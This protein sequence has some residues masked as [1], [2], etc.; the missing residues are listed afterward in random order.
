MAI[1]GIISQEDI[2]TLVAS[3]LANNYKTIELMQSRKSQY[4]TAKADWESIR[5]ASSQLKASL[6]MLATENSFYSRTASSS[7]A[8]I[9]SATA[10]SDA[11][12]GTYSLTDI[13]LAQAAQK[14]SASTLGL[15]GAGQAYYESTNSTGNVESFNWSEDGADISDWTRF[16]VDGTNVAETFDGQTVMRQSV[17]VPGYGK[18]AQLTRNIGALPDQFSISTRMYATDLG[19]LS[20]GNFLKL[21]IDLAGVA[22]NFYFAGDGLYAYDGSVTNEVGTDLVEQNTWTDW[23]FD[24]SRQ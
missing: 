14:A 15:V 24:I 6:A 8:S 23:R 18:G 10:A 17:D 11:P 2:Q 16:A 12:T 22:V 13:I 4:N 7:D 3:S 21:R 9:V 19:N 20:Q 5:K 1:N